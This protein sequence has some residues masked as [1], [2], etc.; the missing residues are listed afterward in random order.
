MACWT[1]AD[2]LRP[3]RP[4]RVLEASAGTAGLIRGLPGI[5]NFKGV[6]YILTKSEQDSKPRLEPESPAPIM[7]T[8]RVRLLFLVVG[9]L[10]LSASWLSAQ[11]IDPF[12]P[13]LLEKAQKSFV[14]GEYRD[15]ARDFEIA[16]FGLTGNKKLQ[17]KAYVYLSLCKY[18]LKDSQAAEK[19]LRDAAALMG[20]EGFSS[21]E[22]YESAWPDLDKLIVLFNLRQPSNQPLP[23]EVA[24]PLPAPSEPPASSSVD[25]GLSKEPEPAKE[26]T[27]PAKPEAAVPRTDGFKLNEIKEGDVVPLNLVDTKPVPVTRVPA[28][29]PSQA[30]LLRIEGTVTVNALVSE[31][32]DVIDARIIKGIKYAAGLEQASLEA[33]RKW[34]FT[35]ASA[36][37]FKVKV[38][39]PISMEFKKKSVP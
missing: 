4:S 19:S 20:Q 2:C 15:A 36:Y 30:S 12:Y 7:N 27:P 23:R 26:E 17:A 18:Y 3:R 29:Y 34:K 6:E 11:Q 21:L 9:F 22:I 10:V 38:W 35:P 39:F 33:V 31:K 8:T 5:D 1:L 14:A 32:G 24:K 28:V 25:P 13:G 37:G 16:A